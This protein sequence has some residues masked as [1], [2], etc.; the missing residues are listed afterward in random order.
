MPTI[1]GVIVAKVITGGLVSTV[2]ENVVLKE[3]LF[4]APSVALTCQK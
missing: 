3:P 1:L 2:N 4:P